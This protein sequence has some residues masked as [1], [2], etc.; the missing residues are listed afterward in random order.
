MKHKVSHKAR[1]GKGKRKGAYYF[2]SSSPTHFPNESY[3]C[4]HIISR[5][6]V[7]FQVRY[8][9]ILL[10]YILHGTNTQQQQQQHQI[11]P[12]LSHPFLT[13]IP[14]THSLSVSVCLSVCP[15]LVTWCDKTRSPPAHTTNQ[16]T[17]SFIRSQIHSVLGRLLGSGGRDT[18]TKAHCYPHPHCCRSSTMQVSKLCRLWLLTS[19]LCRHPV[20]WPPLLSLLR[21]LADPCWGT[22]GKVRGAMVRMALRCRPRR[23][24]LECK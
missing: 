3:A 2:S 17:H 12:S 23:M 5:S 11:P 22:C 13:P 15:S 7:G 18:T 24:E 14:L 10:Y 21:S 9:I 4:K 20:S 6:V 8:Y 19:M 16:N 1:E